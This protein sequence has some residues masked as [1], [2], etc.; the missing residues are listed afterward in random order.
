DLVDNDE[1]HVFGPILLNASS[2]DV[3]LAVHPTDDEIPIENLVVM[4]PTGQVID[5][6][7]AVSANE[8]WVKVPAEMESG[9]VEI[10][11]KSIEFGTTGCTIIPDQ[12]TLR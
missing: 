5:L 12:D 7:Q 2:A 10:S 8:L 1:D 4:D 9:S 11:A 6:D 3:E